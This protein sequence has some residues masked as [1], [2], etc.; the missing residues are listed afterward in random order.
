[1]IYAGERDFIVLVGILYHLYC[2]LHV[3]H[4]AL[5]HGYAGLVKPSL[6]AQMTGK[7]A[8]ECAPVFGVSIVAGLCLYKLHAVG[9]LVVVVEA[10]VPGYHG[11]A[12]DEPVDADI[13]HHKLHVA[14]ED[15]IIERP[16][17]VDVL[18]ACHHRVVM[19]LGLSVP[20]LVHDAGGNAVLSGIGKHLHDGAHCV[21]VRLA[22]EGYLIVSCH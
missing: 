5:V 3:L 17:A 20:G 4:R 14:V 15:G 13:V 10:Q 16:R 18:D 8:Q 7:V 21:E 1:M 12:G 22:P 2:S 19:V 11:V 9:G 6:L